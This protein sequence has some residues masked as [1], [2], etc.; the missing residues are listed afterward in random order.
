VSVNQTASPFGGP[1]GRAAEDDVYAQWRALCAADVAEAEARRADVPELPRSAFNI[2]RACTTIHAASTTIERSEP[3]PPGPEINVEL[4][5][6]G[7]YK[8][9]LEVVLDS[10]V[11]HASRPVRAFVLCRDHTQQDLLVGC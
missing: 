4:S 9:Q 8:H 2:A 1:P 6:D 3:G 5:L 11:E 7:N 10:I